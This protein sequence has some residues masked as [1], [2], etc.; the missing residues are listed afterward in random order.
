MPIYQ[1]QHAQLGTLLT[2]C[3]HNATLLVPDLQRPYVWSP[4]QVIR[5]LDSLLKGWPFGTLLLWNLGSVAQNQTLIPS[6]SFWEVV[7]RTARIG[8]AGT[9][10]SAAQA[11]SNFTMVLDGQQR[12]QSLL[13][14]FSSQAAGMKLFDHEWRNSLVGKYSRKSAYWVLGGIY[15]DLDAIK[16][17]TIESEFGG[18]ELRSDIDFQ[19]VIIWAFNSA[20]LNSVSNGNV[21]HNFALNDVAEYPGRYIGLNRVWSICVGFSSQPQNNRF[22]IAL[23]FLRQQGVIVTAGS[24]L[25]AGFVS[26]V[27]KMSAVY[28][29]R[30]EY[31]ELAPF[32]NSG[33][34]KNDEYSD[35]VVN[36]FTRLNSGGRLLTREEITFAWIKRAWA[37]HTGTAGSA[38][39]AISEFSRKCI[40]A[41][42]KLV[43]STDEIVKIFSIIWTIFDRGGILVRDR[44]LLDGN[45]VQSMA[46]WLSINMY[47]IENGLDGLLKYF[48]DEGIVFGE[49]YRS[50]NAFAI[51]LAYAVG[52]QILILK[53]KNVSQSEY[54]GIGFDSHGING[55]IINNGLRWLIASQWAGEWEKRT[56]VI[57][58]MY[59]VL[60]S[61]EWQKISLMNCGRLPSHQAWSG[62]LVD[63]LNDLIDDVIYYIDDL[64]VSDRSQCLSI[65]T[66]VME[67]TLR[68]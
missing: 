25:L 21:D 55:F 17:N 31:L 26:F 44:D 14:A 23:N 16:K 42:Q 59:S 19:N 5:L 45:T 24:P 8:N 33:Y 34:S 18:A 61:K 39:Q 28:D 67:S 38:D 27:A 12:L 9:C 2:R 10:F 3:T 35:A 46:R 30:V 41:D 57:M 66:M 51:L 68:E 37:T 29:Q 47:L 53:T 40:E 64:E 43:L 54:L 20:Q 15:I 4:D 60:L 36:I 62:V 13:L 49:A 65:S 1:A 22:R 50:I 6:R 52:H 48:V 32:V 63:H 56:D 11:P 7:D 58:E